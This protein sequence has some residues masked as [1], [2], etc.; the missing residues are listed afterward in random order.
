MSELLCHGLESKMD[1]ICNFN[2]KRTRWG[3]CDQPLDKPND[4]SHRLPCKLV[5]SIAYRLLGDEW[6]DG[7]CQPIYFFCPMSRVKQVKL[8]LSIMMERALNSIRSASPFRHRARPT[9]NNCSGAHRN[10][11]NSARLYFYRSAPSIKLLLPNSKIH[12]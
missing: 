1:L 4:L 7:R 11:N 10:R 9:S 8:Y 12:F 2:L 6:C 3:L 5:Y